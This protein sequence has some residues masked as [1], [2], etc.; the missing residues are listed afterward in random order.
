MYWLIMIAIAVGPRG[1][2]PSTALLHI[3]T[4]STID[5]CS[6]AKSEAI[7]KN[8]DATG[9]VQARWFCVRAEDAK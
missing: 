4:F 2:A 8:Q 5:Q 1:S 9:F 6:G 7:A 3:G